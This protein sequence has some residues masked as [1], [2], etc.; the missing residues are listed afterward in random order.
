MVLA[1]E[2]ACVIGGVVRERARRVPVHHLLVCVGVAA[3]PARVGDA[4]VLPAAGAIICRGHASLAIVAADETCLLQLVTMK[5]LD[6]WSKKKD[7][8]KSSVLISILNF[9]INHKWI[10]GPELGRIHNPMDS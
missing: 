4:C 1:V 3:D 10:L 7:G 2:D 6:N 9:I 5:S 8:Y